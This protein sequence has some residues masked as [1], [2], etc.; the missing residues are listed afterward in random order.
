MVGLPT[1]AGRTVPGTLEA[2][3]DPVEEHRQEEVDDLVGDEDAADVGRLGRTD[4]RFDDLAGDLLG[5]ADGPTIRLDR[6]A[7]GW[8]WFVDP[9]PLDSREFRRPGRGPPPV[10][11][12]C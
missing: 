3:A 1:G 4:V 9:T 11:W 6:D 10:A 8:G 2:A 7:A 12:T 5:E